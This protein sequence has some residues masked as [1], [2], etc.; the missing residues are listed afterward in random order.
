MRVLIVKTSSLGDVIHT[1]PAV[2][3]AARALPGIEFD[4]LVEEGFA[5]IP[6]LHPAVKNVIPVALRRWRKRPW[7]A[8]VRSEW[9][10]CRAR[11]Q[12]QPYDAVID[13]QGLIKSAWLAR[14]APGVRY[15]L[16]RQS[17][18]EP[19]ASLA[20]Q[21]KISVSK[22]QH[23]IQRVRQLFAQA[24]GYECADEV[25]YG[26]ELSRLPPAQPQA[27]PYVLFLHGTTWVNKHWPEPY[28]CDLAREVVAAGFRVVLPWGN[29]AERGRAERIAKH[30]GDDVCILPRLSL[31][32]LAAQIVAARAVVGVDTGLS[33]LTAALNVPELVLFGPTN[34]ALTGVLG[35]RQRNLSA[36]FA[37]AP[38]LKRECTYAGQAAVQPACFTTLAPAQVWAKLQTLLSIES[39]GV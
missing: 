8:D 27:K 17:A 33:H 29:D 16:D 9:R 12:Q 20:Y 30:V 11:F 35:A 25:S 10:A 19:L 14:K 15:G 34:A 24:L 4:W 36:E 38:C 13:A 2:N 26:L 39:S 37:C 3:D 18:R 28:W 32:Q 5:E 22:D 31:M 1:L 21:R 6:V 7:A 23:A